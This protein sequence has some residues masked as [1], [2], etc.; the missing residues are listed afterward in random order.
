MVNQDRKAGVRWPH[1]SPLAGGT[2]E[3]V[4]RPVERLLGVLGAPGALHASPILEEELVRTQAFGMAVR[5][6]CC[7][8]LGHAM[9]SGERYVSIWT[10]VP[11]LWGDVM[12]RPDLV[13]LA[14]ASR[15]DALRAVRMVSLFADVE[16]RAPPA[17]RQ[18][19]V[20]DPA[21]WSEELRY[22]REPWLGWACR[23]VAGLYERTGRDPQSAQGVTPID[24][25]VITSALR[26]LE[27]LPE[28]LAALLVPCLSFADA[29]EIARWQKRSLSADRW[30]ALVEEHAL[31]VDPCA[32]AFMHGAEDSWRHDASWS[33]LQPERMAFTDMAKAAPR[34][35][36]E[37]SMS[38]VLLS[39]A[40]RRA[41][42]KAIWFGW[43]DELARSLDVVH[44]VLR[45]RYRFTRASRY[46][47]MELPLRLL[48]AF[49][50]GAEAWQEAAR[51]CKGVLLEA[52]AAGDIAFET[53]FWR[54]M[55]PVLELL[56]EKRPEDPC[57]SALFLRRAELGIVAASAM[58]AVT[59]YE[60]RTHDRD[61]MKRPLQE[62]DRE[63]KG[64]LECAGDDLRRARADGGSRPLGWIR[65]WLDGEAPGD[66]TAEGGSARWQSKNLI[67]EKLARSRAAPVRNAALSIVRA[68]RLLRASVAGP[69]APGPSIHRKPP[70]QTSDVQKAE[71]LLKYALPQLE[72]V[73]ARWGVML[74]RVLLGIDFRSAQGRV[75]DFTFL[76]PIFSDVE[77]R[78]DADARPALEEAVRAATLRALLAQEPFEGT[79]DRWEIVGEL[80]GLAAPGKAG[81]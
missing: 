36:C 1:T 12:G 50:Q 72:A 4:G 76:G 2:L 23:T 44:D 80:C 24:E 78:A 74:I 66:P 48:L 8:G 3:V 32:A 65:D 16:G 21:A 13:R 81:P 19:L 46:C 28:V 18:K 35:R 73:H 25:R 27:R 60:E 56:G 22:P 64:A 63:V 77:Q 68:E 37:S 14:G 38:H 75:P 39:L 11:E 58:Q 29:R 69:W 6:L 62:A 45:H 17:G 30:C 79:G 15:R 61:V 7:A 20:L 40:A 41:V 55:D 57:L 5:A 54:C 9:Q 67:V 34:A 43:S 33:P 42:T 47:A 71:K 10:G 59:R 31:H 26:D 53:F 51:R 70:R 52:R 49:Q